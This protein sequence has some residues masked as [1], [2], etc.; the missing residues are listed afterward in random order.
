MMYRVF[1]ALIFCALSNHTLAGE[2]L[3]P[4]L[5]PKLK[6]ERL[7]EP[8]EPEAEQ[9]LASAPKAISIRFPSGSGGW[10]ADRVA[11]AQNA[12]RTKLAGLDLEFDALAPLG[13]EGGCGTPGA[14][15]I[16]A[17]AGVAIEPPAEANCDL[18]EALHA[19]V[20]W[21]VKPA[22]R[23]HLGKALTVVHNASAFACRRRNNSASGKMSEHAYVNALDISTLGFSDGSETN[24]KG[25]WSGLKQL[26]GLSD[27]S[28]FLRRIRRDACIRFTTVLGPGSDPYHGDHFHIDL[29]RRKN[30]YRICQQSHRNSPHWYFPQSSL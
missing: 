10:P 28:A 17:I 30:G 7:Q 22:A 3:L 14:I 27:K 20:A 19:W 29:A 1:A 2:I 18:A 25:D 5:K 23:E 9:S 4:R 13:Q 11:A 24:I 15:M 8:S 21:S 6:I 12:C 26:V 16:K